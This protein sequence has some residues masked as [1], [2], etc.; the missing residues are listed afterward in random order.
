M[1]YNGGDDGGAALAAP[2]SATTVDPIEG[3]CQGFKGGDFSPT[4][5]KYYPALDWRPGR[6]GDQSYA[7][8]ISGGSARGERPRLL[9]CGSIPHPNRY[10]VKCSQ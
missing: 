9:G 1:G 3:D 10:R 5:E 7:H 2:P 6:S 4:G 8:P